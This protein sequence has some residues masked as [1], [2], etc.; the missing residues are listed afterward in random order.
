MKSNDNIV[1]DSVY[2]K[3]LKSVN[4]ST[5]NQ[6]GSFLEIGKGNEKGDYEETWGNS[7]RCE[8][9]YHPDY[10]NGFPGK[11]KNATNCTI[12]AVFVVCKLCLRIWKIVQCHISISL[13]S[14]F[15]CWWYFIFWPGSWFNR[16]LIWVFVS[17]IYSVCENL[18][19]TCIL[20][21]IYFYFS[22]PGFT[23]K[24]KIT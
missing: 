6:I 21:C 15:E 12:Y 13:V 7:L 11:C 20:F 18:L 10:G 14:Q 17:Y 4:Y 2:M 19:K 24:R 5:R 23:K 22:N 16:V 9:I 8:H 3:I 1:Y